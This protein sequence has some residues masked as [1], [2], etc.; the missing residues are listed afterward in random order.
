MEG[1]VRA[2]FGAAIPE[3]RVPWSGE[4]PRRAREGVS[5]VLVIAPE[6]GVAAG[7]A[8]GVTPT[9]GRRRVGARPDF[10]HQPDPARR[11]GRFAPALAVLS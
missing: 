6:S 11:L 3:A 4:K 7:R 8:A 10:G 9:R 1:L 5:K 2:A